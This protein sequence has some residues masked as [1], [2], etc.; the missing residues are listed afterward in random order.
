MARA[1]LKAE[2]Q[3]IVLTIS[4]LEAHYL[5]NLLQNSLEPYESDRNYKIRKN[6]WETIDPHLDCHVQMITRYTGDDIPF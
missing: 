2:V 3:E 5:L 6:L 4:I 1:R